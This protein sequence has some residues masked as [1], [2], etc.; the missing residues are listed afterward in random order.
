MKPKI[1]F[2]YLF[3]LSLG[4]FSC[5]DNRMDGIIDDKIYLL[6]NNLQV[7]PIFDFGT[8]TYDIV[9]CKSGVLAKDANLVLTIN[10]QLISNYNQVN[11]T[12]Y[13][14]LPASCYEIQSASCYMA[15]KETKGL[16]KIVLN[17]TA[18]VALE[19]YDNVQYVLPCS[20]NAENNIEVDSLKS[21]ILIAPQITKPFLGFENYGMTSNAASVNTSSSMEDVNLPVKIRTNFPNTE[22]IQFKVSV[23][24]SLLQAYNEENNTSYTLPPAGSYELVSSEWNLT[25]SESEKDISLK[26]VMSKLITSQGIWLWGDYVVPLRVSEVSKWNLNPIESVTLVKVS[27]IPTKLDRSN[28]EVIDWNSCIS[29]EPQYEGLHRVPENMLDGN[30]GTYWGSKWDAPKPFPYYFIFDMKE[31]H[32]IYQIGITKPNDSWRGNIK[33]GYFEVS[34][35]NITWIKLSNWSIESNDPREHVYPVK[36]TTARYIRFVIS[37]AFGY[38]GDGPESGANCDIAEFYVW[39]E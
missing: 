8:S 15:T 37:E 4:L 13:K 24:E 7:E 1:S 32:T 38:A 11:G 22:D 10:E 18:I 9:A 31:Q 17:T 39:G 35:D 19:G 20:V 26:M 30:V 28:W 29:E 23:D 27:V 14:L 36:G 3:L 2:L 33:N 25:S 5:E 21:I 12:S 34:G 16:F 6:R